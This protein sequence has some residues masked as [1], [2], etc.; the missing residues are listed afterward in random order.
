M[1]ET[2]VFPLEALV[3][4]LEDAIARAESAGR[5][6]ANGMALATVDADGRPT[7]RTVL[8]KGTDARGL[9]FYTNLG[10]RKAR[11]LEHDPR[12]ALCFWWDVLQEQVLVEGRCERLSDDEADA[13]FATRPRGSQL[14][15]W[16]SRQSEPLESRE[17]LDARVAE[18]ARRFEGREVPR[19]PFWSGF[20]LVPERFEFWYG[21]PDRLHDRFE[22][23]PTPDGWV[24]RR[25]YP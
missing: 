25:L 12:A 5:L 14:G 6:I 10:S 15:A 13:Y 2:T 20:R 19:P 22:Y 21:R 17:V 11:H 9:V 23:R 24:E 4:R 7:V 1:N 8:L 16:A 3:A 18:A